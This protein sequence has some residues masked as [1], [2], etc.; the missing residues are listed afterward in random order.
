MWC[1]FLSFW[2]MII[3]FLKISILIYISTNSMWEF[4]FHFCDNFS[5]MYCNLVIVLL[6]VRHT[7]IPFQVPVACIFFNTV[8]TPCSS[9]SFE[10]FLPVLQVACSLIIVSSAKQKLF[11]QM[12]SY[13]CFCS[14]FLWFPN[15]FQN[16]FA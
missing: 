16:T 3:L 13:I 15:Y 9:S 14:Y 1:C 8:L 11:I 6:M 2:E 5:K 4:M 12:K 10:M 7:S